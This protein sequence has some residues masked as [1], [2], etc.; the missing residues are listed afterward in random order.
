MTQK[1]KITR[2]LIILTLILFLSII[3][4]YLIPEKKEAFVPVTQDDEAG[5][6]EIITGI[7]EKE[8]KEDI[9]VIE[10]QEKTGGKIAVVIDDAGNNVKDLLPFLQFPGKL[11]IA[12]LPQLDYSTES[13]HLIAESGK[14]VLLHQPMEPEKDINPG[15]GALYSTHTG[16]EITKILTENLATVP[17]AKGA[18][19]HMGSKLT[20]DPEKMNIILHFLS[21]QGLY[22]LDSKTTSASVCRKTASL[23]GIPVLERHIF[24]DNI[25]D[26][27]A[28]REQMK[29]GIE[30]AQKNRYV[31]IVGHV[32]NSEVLDILYEYLPEMEEKRYTLVGL[33]EI[34]GK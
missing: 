32:Q 1:Q 10:E 11:S 26:K 8:N 13:A 5:K 2:T 30:L 23:A 24:L 29:K 21:R 16:E 28:I 3:L 22:F 7:E 15:Y 4:V 20:A 18:N 25:V 31:I 14:E 12:V 34:Y 9:P 27:A 33:S 6:D 17:G 19:N